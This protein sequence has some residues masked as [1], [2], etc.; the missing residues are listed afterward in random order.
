MRKDIEAPDLG[1]IKDFFRFY[2]TIS[3]PNNPTGLPTTDSINS[4]AER[5][6]AGFERVTETEISEE[7]RSKVYHV[8]RVTTKR[9]LANIHTVGAEN[10]LSRR[11]RLE[12]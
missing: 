8:S 11:P 5:F 7:D 10:P 9:I 6:F 12:L 4:N 1:T 2:S 3:T